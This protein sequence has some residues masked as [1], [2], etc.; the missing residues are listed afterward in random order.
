MHSH[1]SLANLACNTVTVSALISHNFT[2]LAR[3]RSIDRQCT[4]MYQD[5]LHRPGVQ[6]LTFPQRHREV[7][8]VRLS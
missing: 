3:S 4:Y 8:L 7:I 1:T 6:E 2:V 5:G